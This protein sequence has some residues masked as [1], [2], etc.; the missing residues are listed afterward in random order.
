MHRTMSAHPPLPS[1]F[2]LSVLIV[3]DNPVVLHATR[4]GAYHLGLAVECAEDGRRALDALRRHPVDA[5]LMDLHMPGLDG[6]E[7]T[8]AIRALDAPWADLPIVALSSTASALDR[9]RCRDAGMNAFLGKPADLRTLA[10][11][12]LRLCVPGGAGRPGARTWLDEGEAAADATAPVR[13]A[14]VEP[15]PRALAALGALGAGAPER[16]LE[17]R[18]RGR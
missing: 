15:A 10:H 12:L 13:P 8:L 17:L 4:A 16:D 14:R 2:G 6:F 5:V 7:T 18:L 3:E 1:L 9:R 11:T